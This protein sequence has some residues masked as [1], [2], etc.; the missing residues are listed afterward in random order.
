MT[1]RLAAPLVL[2]VLA[3]L[4]AC[5]DD[6]DATGDGCG[7]GTNCL[8]VGGDAD[9]T[10]D[11]ATDVAS[12]AD[13]DAS[14][15]AAREA[16]LGVAET[17]QWTIPGLHGEVHVLRVEG[18]IPHIFATDE[19]DLRV[20]QG[21]VTARD[22]YFELELGRRFASGT[23][24][25]LLG[26][27]ILEQDLFSV[28]Q[29]MRLVGRRLLEQATPQTLAQYEAYAEGVNAY[30]QAVRDGQLPPPSEFA[31]VGPLLGGLDPVELMQ[32]VTGEDA[33]WFGVFV[34]YQMGYDAIDPAR[35]AMYEQ[36]EGTF[37]GAVFAEERARGLLLDVIDSHAPV[38]PDTATPGFGVSGASNK[39]D[40]MRRDVDRTIGSPVHLPREMRQRA[41]ERA[42]ATSLWLRRDPDGSFGSNGWAVTGEHTADGGALLAGDG[43]LALGI[44]PIFFQ[45]GLDTTVFGSGDNDLRQVGL[46]FPGVPVMGVGT[47]GD[48]AWTQ[49]Y[50]YGDVT[51]WYAEQV[52]LGDDGL[53]SATFFDDRWWDVVR[54]EETFTVAGAFGADPRQE[55]WTLFQTFDGRLLVD[56]EG[57]VLAAPDEAADGEAVA[58]MQGTF[59]VPG[60]TDGDGVITGLSFDFT[61]FDVPDI[62]DDVD[63]WGRAGTVDEFREITRG[64]VAYAQNLVVADRYGDIAYTSFNGTPCRDYLDREASGW[65][66]GANPTR[67]IDGTRYGAFTIPVDDDGLVDD[68]GDTDP[69]QCAIPFERW[70]QVV[71]PEQG[72]VVTANQDVAGNSL[73]DNLANDEFHLGIQ[74]SLGFRAATIGRVLEGYIERGDVSLD[75]MAALQ[76]DHTSPLGLR[77][78]PE[79]IAMIDRAEAWSG[80]EATQPWQERVGALYAADPQGFDDVRTR[81]QAWLDRGAHAASGVD[82]FYDQPDD[83]DRADAVAT[84]VFNAWLMQWLDGLFADEDI[85]FA[86]AL[87]RRGARIR[88]LDR[89]LLGRG[90]DGADVVA[91]WVADTEE[92]AFFDVL[93]TEEVE[94]SDE[95]AAQALA[96]ALAV[97][98]GP[99]RSAGVGGFDTDDMDAWL[100]GLRH[101]VRLQSLLVSFAGDNDLV[102]LI[103][104]DFAITPERL[105]LADGLDDD[106]PR[107][108][109]PWFPRPGDWFNV[110]AAHPTPG[111]DDYFYDAGPVMRMAFHL[112]PDGVQGYNILPGGQ[113]GLVD[114]EHF[115]DQL[116]LWL[117]NRTLPVRF[118]PLDVAAG[119]TGREVF[120]P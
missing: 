18:D 6:P 73:D 23:L 117:G 84:M 72:Y 74:W 60:D 40:P 118:D 46:F 9:A 58:S 36:A 12:D 21:F 120:S 78:G 15:E 61:G 33:L 13:T 108:S 119:A 4:A 32:P 44:P 22:R 55:T 97:L 115:A 24:S 7:E 38:M 47:N 89:M 42:R 64:L 27:V 83:D 106:D 29:G 35:E 107:A 8:D 85:D 17:E 86:F 49:T 109:A 77:Y 28:G 54:I 70:P 102:A 101:Q 112:G 100:W 87:D 10:P 114:S 20:V 67:L 82:T 52:Q 91:S 30:I 94:R 90:A 65:P 71:S 111:R 81:V 95:I 98:R 31:L 110:D 45:T 80:G 5:S 59:V 57:R 63:A 50:L 51:D 53:P 11:V 3:A 105:P 99:R 48:I 79:L 88:L 75:D 103:G 19:H 43:H 2:I 69:Q 41:V 66:E 76:A 116:E 34:I 26:D 62:L 92:S 113:S 25:E 16:L 96:D 39:R 1:R 37:D 104:R 56:V 68:G 14:I 93:G